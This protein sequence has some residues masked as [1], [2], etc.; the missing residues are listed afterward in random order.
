MPTRGP[1]PAP[2]ADLPPLPPEAARVAD[3]RL[4]LPQS[5]ITALQF[6]REDYASLGKPLTA[7]RIRAEQEMI[8]Y[9]HGIP[10]KTLR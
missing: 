3:D 6:L 10:L 8:A 5:R 4:R 7:A 9:C 2:I 1:L